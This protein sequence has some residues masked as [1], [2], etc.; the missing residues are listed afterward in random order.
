MRYLQIGLNLVFTTISVKTPLLLFEL[1]WY[2]VDILS[3]TLHLVYHVAEKIFQTLPILTLI[4][5]LDFYLIGK[6]LSIW[7]LA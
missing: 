6:A 2:F 4:A 5:Q 7:R 1:S 3:G